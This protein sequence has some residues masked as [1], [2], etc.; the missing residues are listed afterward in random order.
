M[1]VNYCNTIENCCICLGDILIYCLSILIFFFK[2]HL[3]NLTW[4][5]VHRTA[6]IHSIHR[7]ISRPGWY[8]E[9]AGM[10]VPGGGGNYLHIHLQCVSY[11]PIRDTC[12]TERDRQRTVHSWTLLCLQDDSSGMYSINCY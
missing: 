2:K 12:A 9:H 11:I 5:A 7:S 10:L 3:Y 6:D 1:T 8:T 4:F